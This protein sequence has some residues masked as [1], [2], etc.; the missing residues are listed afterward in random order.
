MN[1]VLFLRRL[2]RQGLLQNPKNAIPVVLFSIMIVTIVLVGEPPL[3][4]AKE[5]QSDNTAQTNHACTKEP[6]RKEENSG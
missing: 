4:S 2:I 5:P 3:A 1:S 6:C